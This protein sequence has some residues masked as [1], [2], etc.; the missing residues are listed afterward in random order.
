MRKRDRLVI[1][2]D[3]FD[4][5]LSR[6]EGRRVPVSIA[7]RNPSLQEL[8]EAARLAGYR[9]YDAVE[10]SHPKRHRRRSGYVQVAK[11]A[12]KP[13]TSVVLDI[14]KALTRVKAGQRR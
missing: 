8:V 1:W 5:S 14:A 2:L 13:K 7:S 4:S 9:V 12:G 6:R 11:L 3:Y 10:A